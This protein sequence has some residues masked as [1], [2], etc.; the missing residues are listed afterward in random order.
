[1]TVQSKKMSLFESICNTV[2]GF[3]GS[4]LLTW[5]YLRFADVG[6]VSSAL[7]ITMLCTVW[8]LLR[9]YYVRRWFARQSNFHPSR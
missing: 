4:F 5:L 9:G 2:I 1:M 6:V 8:S 7:A 3:V